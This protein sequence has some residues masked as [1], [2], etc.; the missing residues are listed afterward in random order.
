MTIQEVIDGL[1]CLTT[2]QTNCI[3]CP[4]N[5]HPG[6]KWPYGCM[7]GQMDI[8]EEAKKLLGRLTPKPVFRW[9]PMPGPGRPGFPFCPNPECQRGLDEG[10]HICEFCGQAVKWEE[11]DGKE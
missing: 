6:M 5:P 3:G 8:V 4:V 1:D 11:T 10:Q 9:R 2:K 7:K